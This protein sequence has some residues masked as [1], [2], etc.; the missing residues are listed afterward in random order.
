MFFNV[1][2]K[3]FRRSRGQVFQSPLKFV[4]Q[5]RVEFFDTIFNQGESVFEVRRNI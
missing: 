1:V 3:V 2:C 4:E 5:V